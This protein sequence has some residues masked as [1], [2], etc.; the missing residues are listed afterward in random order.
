M[1]AK[2]AAAIGGG[3]AGPAV[4]RSGPW[5]IAEFRDPQA[6]LSSAIVRGGRVRAQTVAWLEVC[7]DDL[8]PPID[9]RRFLRARMAA[10]GLGG[11]GL[12]TS[13]DLDAYVDVARTAGGITVRTIATVGLG[14]ALRVGDAAPSA[15]VGTINILC[16]VS[17]RLRPEAM[18]EAL[19]IAAEARTAAI[20]EAA[21]PSRVSGLL[22]TGTGTDC[23]IVAAGAQGRAE[24]YAGKHTMLGQLIGTSVGEA[25]R[26]GALAWK[27]E[28]RARQ[29]AARG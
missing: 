13:R 16:A 28:Q 9:P 7:S 3:T 6:M 11:V 27:L 15:R 17:A 5:L 18:V 20:L 21:V 26:Q 14:N 8:R 10:R 2:H 12:L 24:P 4:K 29:T 25:V 1:R 22:A 23:I 19:S